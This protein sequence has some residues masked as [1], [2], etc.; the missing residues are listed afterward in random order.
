MGVNFVIVF[1]FLSLLFSL[2]VHEF[3]LNSYFRFVNSFFIRY[4]KAFEIFF[5]RL[6]NFFFFQALK[7]HMLL[8]WVCEFIAENGLK[9]GNSLFSL[10]CQSIVRIR[11][12]TQ[13]LCR[14]QLV[15]V[16]WFWFFLP[17]RFVHFRFHENLHWVTNS[18]NLYKQYVVFEFTKPKR[19]KGK[20]KKLWKFKSFFFFV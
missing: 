20:H 11:Q 4:K 1:L 5:C 16:R 18:Y 15:D 13:T 9:Q 17:K 19:K 7:V 14:V 10:L 6:Y 3:S 12:R 8:T 2:P